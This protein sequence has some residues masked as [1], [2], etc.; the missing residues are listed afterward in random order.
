M[1]PWMEELLLEHRFLQ[2]QIEQV[3]ETWLLLVS[4]W[5]SVFM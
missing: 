3:L 1:T 5:D 2:A 4:I